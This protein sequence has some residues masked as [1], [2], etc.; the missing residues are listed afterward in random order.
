MPARAARGAMRA[1]E[2][3]MSHRTVPSPVDGEPLRLHVGCGPERLPGWVNIDRQELPGV[4]LVADVTHGLPFSGASV[5]YA[6]HFLEHLPLD[7]ALAFLHE[8]HR[9]LAPGGWIR[10]STP[11]LDWVVA[12]HY[13]PYHLAEAAGDAA[14]RLNRGF[15]GWSHRFLWNRALLGEALEACGFDSLRWCRRGESEQ[16]MLRGLERHETY[17]DNAEFPHVLI[18]EGRKAESQPERYAALRKRLEDEFLRFVRAPCYRLDAPRCHVHGR[19]RALGWRGSLA[20]RLQLRATAVDGIAVHRPEAPEEGSL[21]V[22][23][24]AAHL[25]FQPP[26][27]RAL[28]RL[29]RFVHW[30]L[31]RLGGS[32]RLPGGID[33]AQHPL[34]VFQST[35]LEP[36]AAD[37]YLLRGVLTVGGLSQNVETEAEVVAEEGCWQARGVLVLKPIAGVVAPG[38][39]SRRRDAELVV[40]FGLVATPVS[41]T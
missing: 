40:D 17:G 37:R 39:L 3:T 22:E 16:A 24:A 41:P 33:L 27:A 13:A 38:A 6:E 30:L 25:R 7:R 21:R 12:A 28:F 11:N 4:D 9:V 20:P 14:L 2:S 23:I 31:R 5:V 26:L 19:L 8:A 35:S 10:L 18:V 29:R 32:W 34:V 15:H 1:T 36:L